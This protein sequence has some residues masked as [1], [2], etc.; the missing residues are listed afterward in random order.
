MSPPRPIPGLIELRPG[1][2]LNVLRWTLTAENATSTVT[3]PINLMCVHGTAANHEQFIPFL[4]QLESQLPPHVSI[5]CCLYDAVGCGESPALPDLAAYGDDEQV[6]DLFTLATEH[7]DPT[8]PTYLVGH[9]YGPNWIYKL[10]L[11]LENAINVKGL[12]LISS[13]LSNPKYS[14]QKGGP[15]LFRL[16]PLWL[17]RCLQPLLTQSFLQM[18]FS[19]HTHNQQP[20]LIAAAKTVN[21]RNDMKIVCIYYQSHDWVSESEVKSSL[22]GRY[23]PPLI[24][25]GIDDQIVPVECGQD[26]SN[27]WGV[28]LTTIP[29]ASHMVLLEQPRVVAQHV[30]HY[31][32]QS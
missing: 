4:E 8:L 7:L 32:L 20:A 10:L 30:A 11:R 22:R 14:L 19:K 24:L 1:R 23:S 17:L 12:I 27:A 25:H 21:N 2:R 26:L 9:S 5:H 29:N 28:A 13:G 16:V 18:G 31:L 6:Q 15:G 3:R